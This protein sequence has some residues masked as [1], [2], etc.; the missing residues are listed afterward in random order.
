[1]SQNGFVKKIS[2]YCTGE[3]LLPG[4]SCIVTGLSGGP[5]SVALMCVL[6]AMK[7]MSDSFPKLIAVH[8]NHG[9]RES[10]ADD[11]K[12][13]KDLC[14]R[15][16]VEFKSYRF[17]IREQ[18]KKLGRGLEETGRIV[19]YQAFRE[20]AQNAAQSMGVDVSTVRIATA[21]HKGDLTETFLMNLFRGAGLE[22]LTAMS[23]DTMLI[24]P[25]ICVSKEEIL[26]YLKE[27]NIPFA[28][29]ETNLHNDFTRNK[30]RNEII[31]LIS[32]ASVKDPQ[33]AVL[34]TYRL[35]SSDE[36]FISSEAVS[37]YNRCIV[38]KGKYAFLDASG[39]YLLHPAVRSR[40][41]RLYW[42]EL[43]GD[44][45]DFE[46]KHVDIVTGLLEGNNGT[47]YADLPF[48]RKALS[49]DGLL[50]FY[51]D[52]GPQG[53]SCAMSSYLGFPAALM[54]DKVHI[55]KSDLISGPQT[56]K[57]SDFAVSIEVSVI[58]NNDSI[59]YNNL[60]WIGAYD[61]IV[62]G[63]CPSGGTFRKAGSA[64]A[65]EIKKIMSDNRV[66]RD[67]REHLL[68]VSSDDRILFIPGIGHAEG[69]V[70][71]KSR[72]IWNKEK[73][74]SDIK[75]LIKVEISEKE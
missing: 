46:S 55:R 66:P 54:G 22:G 65:V 35:L 49:V 30:W 2:D 56:L 67:A 41:I 18:A 6:A 20:V 24:R 57:M 26:S 17:D 37:A 1:M 61:D 5:D 51:G 45:T 23:S 62:I 47:K 72:Q 69:F 3:G 43:F 12:L 75:T 15:L 40:V 70:S 50:A 8:V 16:Q 9:L 34:D 21:H 29:D 38:R 28:V 36:D 63:A 25:L 33:E 58:E 32:E 4:V 60:S 59:V 48:G 53:V 19:R 71:Q 7:Q 74:N 14:E 39:V 11:E 68:A 10:A 42:K 31:P 64:H 27:E 44:L 73:G 52:E 13:S